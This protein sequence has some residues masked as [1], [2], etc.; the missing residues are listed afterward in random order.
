MQI[1]IPIQ[2]QM[3]VQ[4]QIQIQILIQIQIPIPRLRNSGVD[5]TEST[6]VLPKKYT[7]TISA[8]DRSASLTNPLRFAA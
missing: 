1:Q 5:S 7:G 6:D 3:Q 8:P 4:I 2:I